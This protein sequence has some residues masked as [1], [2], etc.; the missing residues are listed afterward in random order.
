MAP[1]FSSLS[2]ISSLLVGTLLLSGSALSLAQEDVPSFMPT[3]DSSAE[4]KQKLAG[5]IL[6]KFKTKGGIAASAANAALSTILS[7][8]GLEEIDAGMFPSTGLSLLRIKDF[9]VDKAEDI[10]NTKLAALTSAVAAQSGLVEIE[11]A[12]PDRVL[13]ADQTSAPNDPSFGQLWGMTKIGVMDNQPNAGEP[14]AWRQTTGSSNVTVLVIDTG[15]DYNHPD[16]S[17]NTWV[18]PGEIP[19]NGQD[20]DGNGYVD[21]VYGIN[22][23]T[24]SGDPMDDQSHGTHCAGTIGAVGN[25][26]VG[27]VGVS[28]QVKLAGCKFLSAS[29]SGST[30]GAIKCVEYGVRM[31]FTL[32][33]NSWGGG[34]Y[35]QGLKDAIDAAEAIG[36]LFVAAAGNSNTNNDVTPHYPSNYNNDNVISVASTTDTD[37]R[38]G[39]S[40]YGATTVDLGAPGSNILSTIHNN[41]YATYSGTSMATPHVAG[42]AALLYAGNPSL[43]G[44]SGGAQVK[45]ALMLTVDPISALAGKC[46]SEGRLNVGK[47]MEFL[48]NPG[49]SPPPP[50]IAPPNAPPPPPRGAGCFIT[51]GDGTALETGPAADEYMSKNHPNNYANN[52]RGIIEMEGPVCVEFLAFDLEQGYDFVTHVNSAGNQLGRFSGAATPANIQIPAS[53]YERMI[54]TTDFSVVRAGFKVKCHIRAPCPG[55][56]PTPTPTTTTMPTPTTAPPTPTPTTM[57][58][59]MPTPTT[60]PPTTP[61]TTNQTTDYIDKALD[62]VGG[63]IDAGKNATKDVKDGIDKLKENPE[64]AVKIPGKITSAASSTAGSLALASAL[65]LGAAFN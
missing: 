35:S 65:L 8:A 20:D 33:S 18:N 11:Y 34:G 61:P 46:V 9:K 49:P 7:A 1:A 54:F 39:F 52:L 60:M 64:D 42:A 21:D 48:V 2:G 13:Y 63:A 19:G 23:I 58:T 55:G 14:G 51:E 10:V 27:V 24:N 31:G 16:I 12:E 29:G 41:R 62:S 28:Q 43:S 57:P 44:V 17:A 50:P 5:N 59:T 25:N 53:T 56:P 32:T 3:S 38:S 30:S 26:G 40:C 36:Q 45:R 22:A 4:A 47:A 37:G 6:V 15:V